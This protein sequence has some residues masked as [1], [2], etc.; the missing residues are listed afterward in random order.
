MATLRLKLCNNNNNTGM[1]GEPSLLLSNS[2]NRNTLPLILFFTLTRQIIIAG[3][4]V[5]AGCDQLGPS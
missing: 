4:V 5:R 3:V 1:D 2:Y